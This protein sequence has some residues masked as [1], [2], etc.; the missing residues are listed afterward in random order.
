M[1]ILREQMW[2]SQELSFMNVKFIS[3]ALQ[4][5]ISIELSISNVNLWEL[6]FAYMNFMRAKLCECNF[7]ESLSLQ[8]WFFLR[9]EL[10][11]T[12]K[13]LKE[14]SI[15]NVYFM[16][17]DVVNVKLWVCL[18]AKLC[19]C[20]LLCKCEF[21]ESWASLLWNLWELSIANVNFMRF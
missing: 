21:Y 8:M 19:E 18:R 9:A 17:A 7:Y 6:S 16:K 2:I 13:I 20:E 14:L 12:K 3:W 10:A 15:A 11:I 4:M 1:W 5:W